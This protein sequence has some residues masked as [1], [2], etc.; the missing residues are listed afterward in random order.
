LNPDI[1]EVLSALK[2][3]GIIIYPTDTVYGL[4]ADIHSETAVEK[5]HNLKDRT[6][7]EKPISIL[8]K[9]EWIPDYAELSVLAEKR[10]EELLPGPYTI[11]LRKTDKIPLWI[12]NQDYV[13]IR[14]I[15][16][17]IVNEV[18]DKFNSPIT[19]TSANLRGAPP[20]KSIDEIPD[21]ILNSADAVIDTG[22]IISKG[23]STVIKINEKE[24]VLR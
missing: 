7:K 10:I 17:I 14:V 19:T 4:G 16:N 1:S 8:L 13:G 3:G 20:P 24:E 11:V 6:A 9:K 5:I 2:N 18:L 12:T 22:P 15:D 21:V 23:P